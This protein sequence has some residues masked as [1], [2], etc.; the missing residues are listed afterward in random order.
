MKKLKYISTIWILIFSILFQSSGVFAANVQEMKNTAPVANFTVEKSREVKLLV[1]TDYAGTE[2]AN[3]KNALTSMKSELANYA[4]INIEYASPTDKTIGTQQGS[5]T[6]NGWGKSGYASYRKNGYSWNVTPYGQ[7][8][9]QDFIDTPVTDKF[10]YSNTFELPEGQTP[11]QPY[12]VPNRYVKS[13]LKTSTANQMGDRDYYDWTFMNASGIC[14]GTFS[15]TTKYSYNFPNGAVQELNISFTEP[16]FSYEDY[17]SIQWTQDSP[18]TNTVTGWDLSSLNYEVPGNTDTF[19]IFALNNED[20][21]YYTS[22]LASNYRLGQLRSDSNLGKFVKDSDARVYSICS[23]A[24]ENVNLSTNA[25]YPVT[26]KGAAQNISLRDLMDSSF[27]GRSVG[28]KNIT[29]LVNKIKEN[30]KRPSDKVDMIVA[31]DEGSSSTNNFIN[32]IKDNISSDVDFQ[33]NVVNTD[34]MET[35]DTWKKYVTKGDYKNIQT[36]SFTDIDLIL[37]GNGEL[38]ARGSN[39]ICEV[40]TRPDTYTKM[41]GLFGLSTTTQYYDNFVRIATD[42]KEAY[43]YSYYARSIYI[44]KNDN[45]LYVCGGH[46]VRMDLSKGHDVPIYYQTFTPTYFGKVRSISFDITDN[47]IM[48]VVSDSGVWRCFM[49][50]DWAVAPPQKDP[51]AP[52]DT[53]YVFGEGYSDSTLLYYISSDGNIDYTRWRYTEQQKGLNHQGKLPYPIKERIN[54]GVFLCTDGEYYNINGTLIRGSFNFKQIYFSDSGTYALSYDGKIYQPMGGMWGSTNIPVADKILFVQNNYGSGENGLIVRMLTGE[55]GYLGKIDPTNIFRTDITSVGEWES[56][57]YNLDNRTGQPIVFDGTIGDTVADYVQI[58]NRFAYVTKQ[59]NI[60]YITSENTGR[61]DYGYYHYSY[62]T[63][64]CGRV[65]GLFDISDKPVKAFSKSKIFNTPLREDSERYFIYISDNVQKDTYF[66]EPTDYFPFSHLDNTVLNYLN[67]NRFNIYI[68]TPEQARNLKLAYPYVPAARQTLSLKEL[69]YNSVMDSAFCKDKNTVSKLIIK[70]YDTFTKQGSTTLTLI[71]NEESVRYN[72]VYRD[73]END[74]K[75]SEKWQYTHDPAYFDNSNGIDTNSGQWII[76]PLY[77]FSKVGKYIVSAQFRD[78]PKDDNR[79]DNY[80]LWSNKSAPATIIVHRRP[81]ALFSVQ[82]ASRV[83]TNINLS[84]LDQSYDLDH[85]ITRADKGIAQRNWQYKKVDSDTWIDGKPT[86]LTYNTGKYDIQL[87]VRDIEG[88][89]SKPYIDQIDTFNLPPSID[90][91]PTSYTGSGPLNIT[92]T[93]N[94]NGEND[95]VLAGSPITPK[96]RYALTN[97]IVQPITGWINLTSSVY[98]IPP[99]TSDGTYYLHMEAYDTS[100][101]KFYRMRGPYTIETIKAGNFYV[102]MMLDPGWRPYYFDIS[103]G[104]DDNHDGEVD[105]YPRRSNTD[106]GTLKMPINYFSLVG[107]TRTYIKAGYRVKGRIDIQGNPDSAEF[108]IHY[109]T[110]GITYNDTIQL[111]KDS[112]ETYVFDWIIPLETDDKSF[113][114]FDLS[115]RKGANSYG[116]EKWNDTWD[117]RN[118]SK[119]VF[120]VRGKATD[121]LIFVQSQ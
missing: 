27:D 8:K 66:G 117:A 95:L 109:M 51:Y 39:E 42:V 14:A 81:F 118:T 48:Y 41:Y 80:R 17:W 18:V 108:K 21:N 114:S 24:L 99:V 64:N 97:S 121:D 75:H 1:L 35:T 106:I 19:V 76:E 56:D 65:D 70:K 60:C 111:S 119:L 62:K 28:Q 25:Q 93:A 94:D 68:V 112:G 102:T 32:N 15:I 33:T 31:T 90:A 26:F 87:K 38:W 103:Q 9:W 88:A 43:T 37:L 104:I 5:V 46:G 10:V 72:Q 98:N 100:G 86:A 113:V 79:F 67:A 53:Q 34:S 77:T 85:N 23:D 11:T 71:V 36:P 96:T 12:G 57:K 82:V 58:G 63:V 4:K 52:A 107:H 16:T 83:G 69:I 7:S 40:E 91:T 61:D 92:I 22:H 105:R 20:T 45:E 73:F 115:M 55:L 47:W 6:M 59:G 13:S 110:G 74:P 78:N 44:I 54:N 29:G 3:L 30:V 2:N 84:Y 89:W 116:N 50:W 49:D 120:Y 101:Q